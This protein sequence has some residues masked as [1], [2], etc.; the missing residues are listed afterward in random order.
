MLLKSVRRNVS[1]LALVVA[2]SGL[3]P[4]ALAAGETTRQ[5]QLEKEGTE[6]IGQVEDVSRDIHYNADRLNSL[7]RDSQ[8]TRWTHYH[9]LEQI[10]SLVNEGLKPALNR[11]M[12]I[13]PELSSW[14]QDAIDRMLNSAKALA[15]DTDSAIIS[16]NE[17]GTRPIILNTEYADLIEKINGHAETLVKTSDAA[18]DFA[19]AHLK[20]L[21]A[22]LEIP[23]Q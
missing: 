4:A 17:A 9:H 1:V 7:T 5:F 16:K 12:E 22:E 13:Q 15:A 8:V 20:A 2:T 6:L 10:K 18:G 11:L 21:E 19:K 14:K 3:L 23:R